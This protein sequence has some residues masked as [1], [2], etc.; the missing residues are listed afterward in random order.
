MDYSTY[1]DNAMQNQAVI[2]VG[3]IGSVSNGKTS[4][5]KALTG[6]STQKHSEE[7]EKNRTMRL[8]YANAKIYKCQTCDAPECYQ[9]TS[10]DIFEYKC[11]KCGNETKLI[12]HI[13][14]TDVPGHNFLMATMLNGTC[15]MDYTILV[16]SSCSATIPAKQT[17][18]HYKITKESGI[19]PKIVCMNKMDL[20]KTK[21]NGQIKIN[22]MREYLEENGE[23]IP[24]IPVSA[25]LK[26]NIDVLCEYLSGLKIPKKDLS[27]DIKMFIIR[28]FNI[29]NPITSIEN[30]KGGVIGGSLQRGMLKVND[31]VTIYP[32]YINKKNNI[33]EDSYEW[34]YKPLKC[35]I[36][37]IQSEK[38]NMEFAIPGG[39]IGVQL[40]V[41]PAMTSNDRLVGQLVFNEDKEVR[42]VEKILLSYKKLNNY[43][44]KKG[45]K[46]QI[47]INANN[48][49]ATIIKMNDGKKK[50]SSLSENEMMIN[51][52]KPTCIEIGD[53]V[54]INII[55]EN[56]VNIFGKGNVIDGFNC[57]MVI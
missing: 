1:I 45:D 26:C 37:S 52:E 42:V 24:I 47:N 31:I 10:S 41:D 34:E 35:K 15:V 30:L 20:M 53:I 29:N 16:E 43:D 14:I 39:L 48:I 9:S 11:N 38:N 3:I 40:D 46:I 7:K 49:Y 28:S 36:L 19:E 44:V 21:Q 57:K 18:E 51:L 23:K 22:I 50:K 2:N 8:G 13:S 32:G 6:I 17:I 5:T 33:T 4:I 12:T 54:S 55:E 56:I 27:S 25:T